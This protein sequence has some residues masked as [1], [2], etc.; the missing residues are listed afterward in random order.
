M[1]R[2]IATDLDGT[3]LTPQHQLPPGIFDMIRAFREKLPGL[4]PEIKD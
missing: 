1:I 3:L 2:L 4:E